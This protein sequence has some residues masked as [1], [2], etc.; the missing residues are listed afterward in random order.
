MTWVEDD[1]PAWD[2]LKSMYEVGTSKECHP[3]GSKYAMG[4]GFFLPDRDVGPLHA[5]TVA[6]VRVE[7]EAIEVIVA[8]RVMLPDEWQSAIDEKLRLRDYDLAGYQPLDGLSL[9]LAKQID[10][11]DGGPSGPER[12]D[13]RR[14][15]PT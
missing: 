13:P 1:E 11:W 15:H 7:H 10:Q 8:P 6:V 4:Q 12:Q 2:T 3:H 14:P 5:I 9:S